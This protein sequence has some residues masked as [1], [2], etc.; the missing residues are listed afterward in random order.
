MDSVTAKQFDRIIGAINDWKRAN[1]GRVRFI[2]V[3]TAYDK[4][5][6]IRGNESRL[7]AYG[8]KDILS[9]QLEALK[10][11]LSKEKDSVFINW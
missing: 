9:I 11:E 6:N 5:C 1:N 8:D 3:F 10:D 7:F 4:D 2:A